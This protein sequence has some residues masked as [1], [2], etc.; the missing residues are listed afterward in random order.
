MTTSLASLRTALADRYDLLREIGRGGMATVHLARDVR[1]GR[2]VALKL[3]DGAVASSDGDARFDREVRVIARLQHP[4]ILPLFDSGE[5][6][7]VRWF[8]MPF[9]DGE[10]LRARL[11]RESPLPVADAVRLVREVAGA[12][13]Y[14]HTQGVVHRDIKPENIL[15][16][17]GHALVA[18]FGIAR[19]RADAGATLTQAMQLLGTPAYMSPEQ[20]TDGDA[21]DARSDVYSLGCVLYELLA[22]TP[23]FVAP[24]P[25]AVM[26]R[27]VT[28]PVPTPTRT[29]GQLPAPLLAALMRALAK[30][31]AERF[32]TASEFSAA[33]DATTSTGLTNA[34]DTLAT[35]VVLPF[36]NASP[37]PDDA[38]FA[39]GLTDELIGDLGKVRSIRVTSRASAMQLKGT[40]KD[41]RTIGRELGVRYALS[42]SVRRAGP[43]LRVSAQLVDLL[44]DTALW[45]DRFDGAVEDAFE[46]QER[47]SRQIV[48]ALR[49]TL[50]PEESARLAERAAPSVAVFE[51]VVAAREAYF[52]YDFAQVQAAKLLLYEALQDAPDE[53]LLLAWLAR[54]YVH[55]TNV[56]A[57]YREADIALAD[58]FATRALALDDR[59]AEAHTAKSYVLVW[60]TGNVEAHPHLAQAYALQPSTE[61]GILCVSLGVLGRDRELGLG[62]ADELVQRD[63]L[64]PPAYWWSAWTQMWY[65]ET[66]RAQAT[67]RRLATFEWPLAPVL[68]ASTLIHTGEFAEG[69]ELLQRVDFTQPLPVWAENMAIAR[70]ALARQEI[71]SPSERLL[72][73]AARSNPTTAWGVSASY[74]FARD[75]ARTLEWVR[76]AV[77]RG[78]TNR[79]WWLELN[80]TT[81]WLRDDPEF[82][83]IV[84]GGGTD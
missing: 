55:S 63:P 32:A 46:M 71:P 5:D 3:L 67:A 58:R 35:I 39:T 14:A 65:G 50:S 59:L 43:R 16:S 54:L 80:P 52:S 36:E 28:T 66:A 34:P 4:H 31:P 73:Y 75:R 6:A 68:A 8:A 64:N 56:G 61:S 7:G 53:P 17:S 83:A 19:A 22:G 42:G 40:S 33:L 25:Q 37:D 10:S 70:F 82:R 69:L 84:L 21:V 12:L 18:D 60:Q 2:D 51:Y 44:T 47:I 72:H 29:D 24:T 79:R 27:H 26:I 15:L 81:E 38:F 57:G 77:Q 78:F 11:A 76:I 23:P 48:D 30:D 74:A 13:A 45:S 1:H 62:I 20:V 9:I 49:I 41:M